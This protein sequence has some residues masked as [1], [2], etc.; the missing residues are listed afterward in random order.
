MFVKNSNNCHQHRFCD[1]GADV[2]NLSIGILLSIRTKLNI[3]ASNSPTSQS[4]KPLAF[5]GKTETT[6][7]NINKTINKNEYSQLK[8]K[9]HDKKQIKTNFI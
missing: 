4:R 7:K 1:I 9:Q 2:L 6:Q 8:T 5:I 3:C